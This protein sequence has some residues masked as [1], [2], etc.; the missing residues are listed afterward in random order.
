M[1]R[2][3]KGTLTYGVPL[4][5]GEHPWT[6]TDDVDEDGIWT[7]QWADPGEEGQ[8]RSWLGLIEQRLEEGGFTEKW[9]PGGGLVHVGIGLSTNGYPEG[10]A[11]LVL[12]IYEVTATASD[13]SIPVDLVALDHRR[14]VEQWDAKLREALSVL[15]IGST[16]EPGWHLTA[17]YG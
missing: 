5:G 17:S 6:F 11:D 7:P 4:G 1:G 10:E 2:Y 9:E 16:P 14:N 8:E 13:L 15:G 3:A 12:R